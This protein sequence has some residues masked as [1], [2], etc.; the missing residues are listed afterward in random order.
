MAAAEDP[1]PR[2]SGISL[3]CV[4]PMPSAEWSRSKEL[5]S[6]F[7]RPVGTSRPPG[8]KE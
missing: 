6:R 3:A 8:S 5:T 2:A 1:R 7:S 4:K